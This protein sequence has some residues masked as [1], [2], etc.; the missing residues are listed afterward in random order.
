MNKAATIE[1][2]LPAQ[3][4]VQVNASRVGLDRGLVVGALGVAELAPGQVDMRTMMG[5]LKEYRSDLVVAP[6][7]YLLKANSLLPGWLLQENMMVAMRRACVVIMI[8]MLTF[9][10]DSHKTCDIA[11]VTISIEQ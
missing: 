1:R 2:V 4:I 9:H 11:H 8:L 10:I 7:Y 6:N 3:P 5:M